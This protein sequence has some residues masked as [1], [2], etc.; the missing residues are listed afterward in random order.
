MDALQPQRARGMVLLSQHCSALN[1]AE[2][3]Q[4]PAADRLETLIGG[5][6]AR[7]LLTALVRDRSPRAAASA[8]SA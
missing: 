4:Q 6:L 5:E 8:A 1:T 3:P 2:E 7:F